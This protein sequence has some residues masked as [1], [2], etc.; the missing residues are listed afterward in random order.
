MKLGVMFGDTTTSLFSKPNTRF[1]PFDRLEAPERFRGQLVWD[2]ESC[3]G[4]GLCVMDCPAKA[5]ELLMIDKKAKR[6]VLRYHVDR[7][8]FCEQCVYSCNKGSLALANN[9][10][11]MA[12]LN[13]EPFTIDTGTP[14]DLE[15]VHAGS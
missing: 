1:Y 13:K 6:F 7:C 15:T 5:I 2:K 9:I 4:C 10:W 11:E 3:T 14:E 12:A 8:T